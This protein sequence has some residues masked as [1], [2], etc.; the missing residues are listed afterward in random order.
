MGER[1]SR[2]QITS[3]HKD[4]GPKCC[5]MSTDMPILCVWR[6]IWLHTEARSESRISGGDLPGA[7][8]I[9]L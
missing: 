5:I 1:G 7:V 9:I 2:G 3:P 4:N 8:K 6:Q